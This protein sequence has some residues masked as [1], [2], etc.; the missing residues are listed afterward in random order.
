VG[1]P[2]VYKSEYGPPTKVRVAAIYRDIRSEPLNPACCGLQLLIFGPRGALLFGDDTQNAIPPV[3]LMDRKTFAT[4]VMPYRGKGAMM[5]PL[6]DR[7]V[8]VN[9][10]PQVLSTIKKVDAADGPPFRHC[11]GCEST[12]SLLS[13]F[14]IRSEL[15]R[16][17]IKP[18]V[19]PITAA[20]VLVGLVVVAAAAMF[21]VLRRRREL[22]VLPAHGMGAI[23]LGVKAMLEALPALVTGAAGLGIG[24]AIALGLTYALSAG[25]DVDPSLP[26]NTLITVPFAVIT[27]IAARPP[28]YVYS[29]PAFAPLRLARANPAEV[30][31]DTV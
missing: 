19:L 27:G 28:P 15:A 29:R 22:T 9:E 5:F 4:G 26:P 18:T 6:V 8:P 21:W 12:S 20:G 13:S 10:T 30:L 23:S 25:F 7:N 2:L 24:L 1:E 16:T 31:R 14:A 17:G 3:I 11:P